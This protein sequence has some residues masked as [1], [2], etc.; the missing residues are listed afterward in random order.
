MNESKQC[1]DCDGTMETGFILDHGR[2]IALQSS[3]YP[4]IPEKGK[5]FGLKM[6]GLGVVYDPGK[7]LPV[8]AFRCTQCGLVR[9]YSISS[10]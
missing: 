10:T 4:G 7:G 5:L 1:P 6:N 8:T 9:L 3:W 2:H